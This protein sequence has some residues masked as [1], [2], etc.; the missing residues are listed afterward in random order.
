MY[1][2]VEWRI[3]AIDHDSC[4]NSNSGLSLVSIT[5]DDTILAHK[6]FN[7]LFNDRRLEHELIIEN[8]FAD[9]KLFLDICVNKIDNILKDVPENW[10]LDLGT[11][12]EFLLNNLFSMNWIEET[13]DTFKRFYTINL[14]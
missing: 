10:N 14:R 3:Y 12:R 6:L 4:F 11:I 2:I 7:M 5:E 1:L 8:L 9:F 13:N